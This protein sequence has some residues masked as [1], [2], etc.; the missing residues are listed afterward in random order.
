MPIS[1]VHMPYTEGRK[2][3]AATIIRLGNCPSFQRHTKHM[4]WITIT[5]NIHMLCEV[6]P[7]NNALQFL[8]VCYIT[9]GNIVS[10]LLTKVIFFNMPCEISAVLLMSGG[11][12]THTHTHARP[13]V[14]T[15][16]HPAP[17]KLY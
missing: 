5:C 12:D 13:P 15:S 4:E 14:P 10:H 11:K 9:L 3:Q 7:T 17:Y 2:Q 6:T 8:T 1:V 16:L